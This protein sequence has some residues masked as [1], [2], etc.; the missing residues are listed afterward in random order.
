MFCGIKTSFEGSKIA[1]LCKHEECVLKKS[2]ISVHNTKYLLPFVILFLNA[3]IG[4]LSMRL[5]MKKKKR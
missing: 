5:K 2:R 4:G 3:E 1:R